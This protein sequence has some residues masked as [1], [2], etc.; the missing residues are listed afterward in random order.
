MR[1][2]CPKCGHPLEIIECCGGG[3][4]RCDKC[5]EYYYYGE[6]IDPSQCPETS[7]EDPS[8]PDADPPREPP[9]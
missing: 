9:S 6:L 2:D 8:Q 7:E 1:E 5:G 3:I 4:W